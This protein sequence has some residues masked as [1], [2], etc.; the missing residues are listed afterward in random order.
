MQLCVIVHGHYVCLC[1]VSV[2]INENTLANVAIPEIHKLLV[3][4]I[5]PDFGILDKLLASKALSRVEIAE[6]KKL[7]TPHEKNSRLLELVT[8]NEKLKEFFNALKDTHQEH[9]VNYVTAKGGWL[10]KF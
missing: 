9:L 8:E 1:F 2:E 3:E 7:S 5:N 10:C 6:V 4:R